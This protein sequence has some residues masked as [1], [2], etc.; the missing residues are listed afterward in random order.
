MEP[1]QTPILMKDEKLHTPTGALGFASLNV[2]GGNHRSHV[3]VHNGPDGV[4]ESFFQTGDARLLSLGL[5]R[6]EI[7]TIDQAEHA[8]GKVQA[9]IDKV[10]VQRSRL[11]A[12][13]SRIT[14]S[15]QAS[16][17]Y[18]DN[19]SA[20]EA[21]M[22]DTDI[23]QESADLAEYQVRHQASI[24]LLAQANQSPRVALGLLQR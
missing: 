7:G 14:F 23:V 15:Y 20:A 1:G 22:T 3:R 10:S 19:I 11:G 24:A 18:T 21:I 2:D 16:L 12:E 5:S 6:T 4:Q 9:A 17:S 8:L 13:A